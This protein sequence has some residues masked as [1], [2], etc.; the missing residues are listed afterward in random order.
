MGA[1][2]PLR[3]GDQDRHEAVLALSDEF[4]EGRLDRDEFDRRQAIALQATYLHDLDP[5][6]ADLPGRVAP[7][8]RTTARPPALVPARTAPRSAALAAFALL[9]V[10][11]SIALVAL[12]VGS[13]VTGH[14]VWLLVPLAVFVVARRSRRRAYRYAIARQALGPDHAAF[15]PPMSFAHARAHRPRGCGGR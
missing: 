1:E 15:V 9:S 8:S 4:A 7:T 6:F 11:G 3:A 10:L 5:L 14:L 13:V 2:A 12:T